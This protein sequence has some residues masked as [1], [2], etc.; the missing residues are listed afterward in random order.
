[1]A[2]LV[3][4]GHASLGSGKLRKMEDTQEV[5]AAGRGVSRKPTGICE[6]KWAVRRATWTSLGKW[7]SRDNESAMV[8][9]SPAIHSL[10]S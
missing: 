7:V 4:L 6:G 2:L 10:T 3:S 8:F 1:M 5:I 9:S